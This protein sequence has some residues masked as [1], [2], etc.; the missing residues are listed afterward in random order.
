MNFF[1]MKVC[2]VLAKPGE[3]V[4]FHLILGLL[5]SVV[6]WNTQRFH[7][8]LQ[9]FQKKSSPS[10]LKCFKM[11][12]LCAL[13]SILRTAFG[14]LI[15]RELRSTWCLETYYETVQED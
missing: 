4:H 3:F 14:N 9:F 5:I 8:Q 1:Y 15:G 2:F 11:L 7:P 13:C 10:S 6:S 12:I